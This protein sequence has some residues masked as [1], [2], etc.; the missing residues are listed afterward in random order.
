MT[1]V[2]GKQDFERLS[3]DGSAICKH[4]HVSS[5]RVIA[6]QT[7]LIITMRRARC[8]ITEIGTVPGD[9]PVLPCS[10]LLWRRN[11]QT[12]PKSHQIALKRRY[13]R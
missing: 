4:T 2:H 13:D 11:R 1:F 12:R 3:R 9:G 5:N 7:H 6:Y 8:R 10:R